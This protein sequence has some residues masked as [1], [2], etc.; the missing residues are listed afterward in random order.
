[1]LFSQENTETNVDWRG[2]W[3]RLCFSDIAR[4][5]CGIAEARLQGYFARVYHHIRFCRNWS[6]P[7]DSFKHVFAKE[8]PVD[9]IADPTIV[10]LSLDRSRGGCVTYQPSG[11]ALGALEG[12]NT[13][14]FDFLTLCGWNLV[15]QTQWSLRRF[16]M[17]LL[18]WEQ[19]FLPSL[20]NESVGI[21]N[22]KFAVFLFITSTQMHL[23]HVV[24]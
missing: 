11:A 7:L 15:L 10:I 13:L 3:P 8:T 20:E 4:Q 23:F 22:S 14:E 16:R 17:L 18:H 9:V 12:E 6:V 1:M 24:W 19:I 5:P 21:Y 2:L